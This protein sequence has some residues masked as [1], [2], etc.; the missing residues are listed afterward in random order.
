M[1]IPESDIT[2]KTPKS[3]ERGIKRVLRIQP[4]CATTLNASMGP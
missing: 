2:D 1:M 4:L 3:P